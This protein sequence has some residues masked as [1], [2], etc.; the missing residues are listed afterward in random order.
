[1]RLFVNHKYLVALL[2][3]LFLISVVTACSAQKP[4]P[5]SDDMQNKAISENQ[6]LNRELLHVPSP[7]WQDQIIYFLM[8][9]RFN[10]GDPTNNDMG[11]GEYDPSKES[12]YN[13]GDIPGITQKIDY[14][15]D[16]GATAVWLT[17]PVANQWWSSDSEYSGYH[18]Y[19]ARDF[20]KVDEHYGTLE[21]YKALSAALHQKGMYL[22]QDIVVNHTGI[23]FG[24]QGEYDPEDTAKN[25]VLFE[26]GFQ[27]APEMAPF[28]RVNRLNPEHAEAA[29]YNWTPGTSN[30]QSLEQQFT[31][32]LGNLSDI[33]TK[34]PAV[35]A[36]F[37]DAY[38]WWMTEVGVDAFR[39][40]TVKY[41]EHSFWQQF[42][43]DQDGIYAQA[44][45]LGKNHF[46]TFGEV[47]EASKPFD[48]EGE[49]KVV[50]FLG[51]EDKPELN[52]V[53]G[54]P[55]YF[56]IGSVLGEGKPTAQ[57]AFRLQAFMEM[58]PDP[59]VIP[60]FI[61]NHDTKRFLAG[62]SEAALKQALALLL[63]IPGIPVIYQGTEQGHQESRQ[64]MFAGGFLS[65]QDQFNRDSELFQYI[66]ALAAIRKAHPIF[67][68]GDLT[69]L[70]S[71][72][73]GPGVL[74][75]KRQYQGQTAIIVI[76]SAD[77]AVLLH[78]VETGLQAGTQLLSLYQ[79]FALTTPEIAAE[80]NLSMELP[81][82]AVAVYLSSDKPPQASEK[83]APQV[84]IHLDSPIDG[85]VFEQDILVSGTFSEADATI[86]LILNGNLDT[87]KRI[88]T[89]R[90]GRWQ[91]VLPV[92]N[93]GETQYELQLYAPDHNFV[94]DTQR[95][96]ARVSEPQVQV[97]VADAK[98]DD[99]G[100]SGHYLRPQQKASEQ[101]MD[102]LQ[103]DAQ[104]AGSNLKLTLKMN[105]ISDYWLP[106][107]GFD[108]TSFTLFFDF[109]EQEGAYALPL[110]NATMPENRNW[111]LA[112][113]A[114]GWGNYMYRSA[115][116]SANEMGQKVGIAPQVSVDKDKVEISFFYR[117]EQFGV[118]DWQDVFIYLTTWDISGEGAYRELTPKG[119]E[120]QFGGGEHHD[121]K[122]MDSVKL[123]LSALQ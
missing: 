82:R 107:N 27:S 31:Y 43:H 22:I 24:Y 95:F 9:D 97:I 62:A 5:A 3:Y 118:N 26:Q 106:S 36:A 75:Y 18:G 80:G 1:M 59:H 86:K 116:A 70:A 81:A 34:N 76:N 56:E 48:T 89:D 113:V 15:Q 58:Y 92:R 64:A 102:I 39:I 53:I 98:G 33:N 41:V 122:I 68:R 108:N 79:N 32:Q 78:G 120:W 45:D 104:T 101:Q 44:E 74:V 16:L 21:D 114:Y 91:A 52:S 69:L 57:L 87:A 14:I 71:N 8:T 65:E 50:S 51:S 83:K 12:H 123:Q 88:K 7:Q 121:A 90:Q 2:L 60:N 30:Y 46:L 85:K 10:D 28:H 19:W 109:P 13:G 25:F 93:L 11:R 67:S 100:E 103:V 61:D 4:Q 63:T 38:R 96:I 84:S 110:L 119:G 72:R 115:H 54:F 42:L 49:S 40:D 55:L 105:Q 112:H 35:I 6:T 17:P 47:F 111:D 20:K 94:S 29:I 117:G 99:R 37:K 66:K 73:S 23:F 77:H